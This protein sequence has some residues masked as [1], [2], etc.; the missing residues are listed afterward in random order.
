[1][2]PKPGVIDL[3]AMEIENGP[4]EASAVGSDAAAGVGALSAVFPD[5][6][7]WKLAAGS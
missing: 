7:G 3:E 5:A 6:S 2:K 4:V 1:M